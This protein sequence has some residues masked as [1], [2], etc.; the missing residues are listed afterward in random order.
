MKRL[1][2]IGIGA[3]LLS[4]FMQSCK[5]KQMVVAPKKVKH[6]SVGKVTR[7]AKDNALK[8]ET[9]SVKKVSITLNNNGKSS[10]VKGSFKI[11]RDSIIQVYA[12]KLAIPVGKLEIDP[13]SFRIAYNLEQEN[14]Y[15]SIDY[16]SD[17]LGMDIDFNVVQSILTDQIFSFKQDSRD[18]KFRDFACEIEDDMY[19]I[20]TMRDRKLRKLSKNEDRYERYRNRKEDGHM[21]RQDIYID[22]DSFVVRKVILDDM[23][24]KRVVK[25][26]FANFEKVD[27]QWYPTIIHMNYIGE[28]KLDLSIELSKISLNDEKNFGFTLAPKY[29]K[30]ILQTNLETTNY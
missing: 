13:D 12:Q 11:R 4:A 1:I 20:T 19:K 7:L 8:F 25:F 24:Y 21:I 3:L 5:Q 6:L 10:S 29:K 22:P 30:K 16:I 23:D 14:I 28:K 18:R 27:N 2:I 17:L 9:V 15:G 26:A